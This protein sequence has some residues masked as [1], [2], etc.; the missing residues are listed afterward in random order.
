MT[1]IDISKKESEL[2]I[3]WFSNNHM[4]A[5]ASKFHHM[6]ISDAKSIPEYDLVIDN[7]SIDREFNVKLLG[8]H[9]DDNL[10]FNKHIQEL[11][12]KTGTQLNVLARLASNLDKPS[13]LA[14]FRCFICSHFNYCSL[15][16]FFCGKTNSKKLEAI[17]E[18]ALRF[19]SQDFESSY[20]AL[21]DGFSLSTLE[22]RR[23]RTLATLMYKVN[24]NM[25]PSYVCDIFSSREC[26]H[27]LRVYNHDKQL[28]VPNV[29]KT[30]C[31][32]H[33][34]RFFAPKLWNNLSNEM[35]NAVNIK[36]FKDLVNS[37]NG[38]KCECT[39]CTS[40]S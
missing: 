9:F 1:A 17:H 4:E 7:S 21:L 15:V 33:S 39:F 34:L 6:L 22:L 37:W 36:D 23:T 28:T 24:N 31:G 38:F 16:W 14:I 40:K 10:N 29:N 25:A 27:D 20:D 32:L 13:R 19:V 3:E 5:N 8:V 2:A 18:R 35:V 30:R 11:C 26:S 12:K